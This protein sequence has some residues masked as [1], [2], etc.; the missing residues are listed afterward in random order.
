M[1]GGEANTRANRFT[2]AKTTGNVGIGTAVPDR[3]LEIQ[4]HGAPELRIEDSDGDILAF[5]FKVDEG[6]GLSVIEVPGGGSNAGTQRLTIAKGTGKVGVGTNT[7]A[8]LLTIT[9][10]CALAATAAPRFRRSPRPTG[11]I[12]RTTKA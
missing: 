12:S 6:E 1:P 5:D 11:W 7:P 9:A 4:G 8:S 3:K 2:I 10:S